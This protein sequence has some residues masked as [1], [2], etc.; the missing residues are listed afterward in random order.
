MRRDLKRGM[1]RLRQRLEGRRGREVDPSLS[2][3]RLPGI[4]MSE[5]NRRVL[6][7][8]GLV[9]YVGSFMRSGGMDCTPSGD[10]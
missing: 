7:I 6:A 2:E 8:R 9:H 10:M 3:T 1:D 5:Q 4:R